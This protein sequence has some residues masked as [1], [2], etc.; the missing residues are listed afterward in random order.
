VKLRRWDI[1]FVKA[2]ERD[3]VGH[4]GVVLSPEDILED[5]KQHR[6]NVLIGTKRVP[7]AIVQTHQVLLNGADGLE[8]QTMVDCSLVYMVKKASIIRVTGTVGFFRRQEI[9]R[10]IRAHLGLG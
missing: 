2:D 10:K 4:P 8:F 1:V 3:Q 7:A 5:G 6:L 9:Q